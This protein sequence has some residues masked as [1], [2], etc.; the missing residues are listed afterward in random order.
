MYGMKISRA[1]FVVTIVFISCFTTLA[2][3]EV[4][5]Q[6]KVLQVTNSDGYTYLH[7]QENSVKK[8]VA[9]P[10]TRVN[11]K[12]VIEYAET[13]PMLNFRSKTLNKKFDKISFVPS[14]R[15]ILSDAKPTNTSAVQ[16]QKSSS[17]KY[18]QLRNIFSNFISEVPILKLDTSVQYPGA[19]DTTGVKAAGMSPDGKYLA[20]SSDSSGNR[21]NFLSIYNLY[22][23]S[24]VKSIMSDGIYTI[25][26]FSNNNLLAAYNQGSI[27]IYNTLTWE[28]IKSIPADNIMSI[29]FNNSGDLIAI[30]TYSDVHIFETEKYKKITKIG[31]VNSGISIKYTRFSSDGSALIVIG[32]TNGKW[33]SS[34]YNIMNWGL[35][36]NNEHG[37]TSSVAISSN[38][39]YTVIANGYGANV[40]NN[41]NNNILK[42]IRYN[43]SITSVDFDVN[44]NLLYA[45]VYTRPI[46]IYWTRDWQV[47]TSASNVQDVNDRYFIYKRREELGDYRVRE[48]IQVY[49]SSRLGLLFMMADLI[50]NGM[51]NISGKLTIDFL[52]IEKRYSETINNLIKENDT[53]IAKINVRNKS[54]FE[55]VDEYNKRIS[56]IDISIANLNDVFNDN[57][58]K[59]VI[60]RAKE[61]GDL[62]DEYKS[63]ANKQLESKKQ[64]LN[65]LS[66]TLGTYSAEAELFPISVSS[67]SKRSNYA[68]EDNKWYGVVRV[69]RNK[70]EQFKSDSP[71]FIVTAEKIIAINGLIELQNIV[72]TS[73]GSTETYKIGW[74]QHQKPTEEPKAEEEKKAA[75][76]ELTQQTNKET[77][78]S[79]TTPVENSEVDCANK[80]NFVQ[81]KKLVKNFYDQ[82]GEWA[83][84]FEMDVVSRINISRLD[85]KH[86]EAQVEYIYKPVVGNKAGRVDIGT[87]KRV[88]IIE[89]I[90]LTLSVS[91]MKGHMSANF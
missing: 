60:N 46:D 4:I 3:A 80:E 70:A 85:S 22:N 54:E 90:G 68:K 19:T 55:T 74:K 62:I 71:N 50:T 63:L 66:V 9:C 15:V 88:F 59:Y 25:L 81:I 8:W 69:P 13:P 40:V 14:I 56:S 79:N 83:N 10:E 30:A 77:E 23:G 36:S 16:P 17:D 28:I 57:R 12:D 75:V 41:N 44:S 20:V 18:S 32:E 26:K 64:Q 51:E 43:S 86:C 89:E 76:A 73:P 78:L 31:Q 34:V 2:V 58:R 53:A 21:N 72:I 87:D 6:G 49:D 38:L 7:V 27:D 61:F 47:L 35:I 84:I 48:T 24:V 67:T 33:N 45:S 5:R 11:V 65:N 1:I 91:E 42:E 52:K 82:K 37:Y 39:K 29:D